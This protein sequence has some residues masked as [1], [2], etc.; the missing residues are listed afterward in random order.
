MDES[1]PDAENAAAA[2][3]ATASGPLAVAGAAASGQPAADAAVKFAAVSADFKAKNLQTAKLGRIPCA[4]ASADFKS[5]TGCNRCGS[6]HGL[7]MW[8]EEV[9]V[10]DKHGL[11]IERVTLEWTCA[12]TPDGLYICRSCNA[13]RG[14]RQTKSEHGF[15]NAFALA[16]H[17]MKCPAAC[18]VMKTPRVDRSEEFPEVHEG[19]SESKIVVAAKL[20]GTMRIICGAAK[21]GACCKS[22]LNSQSV[23]CDFFS[24][25]AG[26]FTL[27][28]IEWKRP[29]RLLSTQELVDR[30]DLSELRLASCCERFDDPN[31]CFLGD[32]TLIVLL[33]TLETRLF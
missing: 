7:C 11:V 26:H 4:A 32:H 15:T 28:H 33:P 23:C 25:C 14:I 19:D 20:F 30:F 31:L 21:S 6:P 18:A 27:P 17:C 29:P 16:I 5:E 22:V 1:M 2:A 13:W 3:G 24:E 12:K 8:Y 10:T 9:T